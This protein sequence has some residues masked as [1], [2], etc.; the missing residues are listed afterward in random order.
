MPNESNLI[1]IINR[2]ENAMKGKM[3]KKLLPLLFLVTL[4]I[5][6][7]SCVGTKPADSSG[8]PTG[9]TGG[10]T[11]QTGQKQPVKLTLFVDESWWPYDTWEGAIPEEFNRRM[12]VE[13][14]VTR[15]ADDKQLPMMVA[16]GDMTDIVC[17]YRYQFMADEEVSYALDVLHSEYPDVDFPVHSVLQF[18]NRAPD[19]HYYTIGCGYS[20][21]QS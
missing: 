17:S 20:R 9:E 21:T 8:G 11:A 16:S 5:L 14:E 10:S 13:I 3:K 1:K 6:F 7:S 12:N 4:T 15:A 2:R 18:V 19:G